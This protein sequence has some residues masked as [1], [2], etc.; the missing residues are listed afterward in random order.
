MIVF[1]NKEEFE[2]FFSN[3]KTKKIDN[4]LEFKKFDNYEENKILIVAPHAC[5]GKYL[6]NIKGKNMLIPGGEKNVA[7]L[8]KIAS[9]N[10]GCAF[11][12]S[13]VPRFEA[14]FARGIEDLGKGLVLNFLVGEKRIPI[15]IH[16]NKKYLN[17]LKKFHK[18]IEKID[19]SFIL[20]FHGTFI[21]NFDALFG[22]GKEKR[23]ISGK[24]L[25]FKFRREVVKKMKE[26]KEDVKVGIAKKIYVGRSEYILN[27]HVK[28]NKKGVLVEFAK[29]GRIPFPSIKY[30]IL[31][32]VIAETAKK[33][34]IE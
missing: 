21:R 26:M 23:F 32:T 24:K 28:G 25:A 3:I 16:T 1:K 9:Y 11:L 15:K 20:S 8:T 19:P 4:Y 7:E 10:V 5:K 33:Y 27:T 34:C 2:N 17:L 18:I 29:K 30:Q 14:D 12:I 6:L 22:F 13:Y 31:A